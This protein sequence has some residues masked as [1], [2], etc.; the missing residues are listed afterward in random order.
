MKAN[1][2]RHCAGRPRFAA[3]LV[4]LALEARA[5]QSWTD[6]RREWE[7]VVV[8]TSPGGDI[9]TVPHGSLYHTFR[10]AL[11]K[12]ERIVPGGMSSWQ[13]LDALAASYQFCGLAEGIGNVDSEIASVSLVNAGVTSLAREAW[14]PAFRLTE[15]AVA[16]ALIRVFA[17][18]R[19]PAPVLRMVN[20]LPALRVSNTG[21]TVRAVVARGMWRPLV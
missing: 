15:P 11:S 7:C 19:I 5:G 6:I 10:T 8:G 21:V 18:L 12:D 1:F 3:T 9:S 16:T 17:D 2:H 14:C 20:L 13:V 4:S